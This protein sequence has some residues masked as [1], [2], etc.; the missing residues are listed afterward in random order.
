M[1]RDLAAQGKAILLYTTDYDELI[2]CCDRVAVMYDGE[3]I[4]E[5]SGDELTEQNIVASSL[6]IEPGP[7][8]DP[9]QAE[10]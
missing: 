10:T 3:I 9:R 7:G 4:R 6:N 5:L 1:L 8:A 2:G